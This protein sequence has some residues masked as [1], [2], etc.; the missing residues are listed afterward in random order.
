VIFD[1]ITPHVRQPRNAGCCNFL[2]VYFINEGDPCRTQTKVTRTRAANAKGARNRVAKISNTHSTMTAKA[3][4]GP[5]VEARANRVVNQVIV[6]IRTVS[7]A[8]RKIGPKTHHRTE[9][10]PGSSGALLSERSRALR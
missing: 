1:V 2:G 10:A 5:R 4:R 8:A 6:A 7:Q 3:S 9:G